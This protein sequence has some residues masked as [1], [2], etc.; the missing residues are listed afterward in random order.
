M[1]ED[2]LDS[3]CWNFSDHNPAEGV[4]DAGVDT[5]EGEGGIEGVI[6]MELD[7]E[8]LLDLLGGVVKKDGG[9]K[10]LGELLQAPFVVFARMV[11]GEVCGCDI[12][13]CFRVDAYNLLRIRT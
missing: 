10:H 11:A 12:C 4:G 9:S 3:Q 8:T 2:I 6:F 13:N 1:Y 5:N 7:F